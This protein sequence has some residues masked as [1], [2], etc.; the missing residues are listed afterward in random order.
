MTYDRNRQTNADVGKD[1]DE[2]MRTRRGEGGREGGER[3]GGRGGG[4]GGGRGACTH[5]SKWQFPE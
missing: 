5:F 1:E 2:L 4:G 3:E